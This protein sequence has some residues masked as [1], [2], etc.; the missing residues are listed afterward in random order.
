MYPVKKA[1]TVP[2]S[3]AAH[4]MYLLS[5]IAVPSRLPHQLWYNGMEQLKDQ[6][7]HPFQG[8]YPVGETL[9][10]KYPADA[11]MA[12]YTFTGNEKNPVLVEDLS[13][14]TRTELGI[15]ADAKPVDKVFNPNYREYDDLPHLTKMSN[16]LATMALAKSIDSWLSSL[17]GIAYSERNIVDMLMNAIA[18]ADSPEMFHILHGNHVAWCSLAYMRDGRM[19]ADITKQFYGQ[20]DPEFYIKDLGT[21]MPAILYSLAILGVRPVNAVNKMGFDVWGIN[22][23]ANSLD[24]YCA[25]DLA[26]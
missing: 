18:R 25:E 11:P 13:S 3:G 16:E 20:T 17:F 2:G 1:S 12:D 7:G 9:E 23:V 19:E 21:I 8:F 10:L 14:A 24:E 22:D 5:T 4:Y 26:A 6:P 15:S